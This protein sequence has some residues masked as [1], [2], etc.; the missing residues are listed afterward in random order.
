MAVLKYKDNEGFKSLYSEA[1]KN[2][3]RKDQNL[4]DVTNVQ[5]ARENLELTGDNNH[6]HYHDD[7]YLPKIE[8]EAEQ[9]ENADNELKNLI[10][11]KS[12]EIINITNNTINNL[13][14]SINDK[15]DST[16]SQEVIDRNNAISEEESERKKADAE[17]QNAING[18]NS[19]LNQEITDRINADNELRTDLDQEISDRKNADDIAT[20]DRNSIRDA[21]NQEIIDRTNADNTLQSNLDNLEDTLTDT[22]NKEIVDRQN[23]NQNLQNQITQ[24][25][26]QATQAVNAVNSQYVNGSSHPTGSITITTGSSFGNCGTETTMNTGKGLGAGTYSLNDLLNKLVNISHNHSFSSRQ[27]NCNCNCN[28]HSH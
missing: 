7:R 12:E 4:A 10:S 8:A 1:I 23:A 15:I 2:R 18:L 13:K 14:D 6:T 28:T 11:D 22:I 21:L 27:L 5:E 9:R 17:L 24:V 26:N 3:L 19:S 16:I 20:T 25:Q